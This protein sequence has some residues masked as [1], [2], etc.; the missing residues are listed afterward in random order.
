MRICIDSAE[1]AASSEARAAYE[2]MARNY[3]AA[4]DAI[5]RSEGPMFGRWLK[6]SLIVAA[7]FA[8]WLALAV[9]TF[10]GSVDIDR[11]I[12]GDR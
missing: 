1:Q 12:M 6:I 9:A 4:I 8:G 7:C 10:N 11:A 5:P 2:Q 3:R